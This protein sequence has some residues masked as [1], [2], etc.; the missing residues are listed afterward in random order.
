MT[1]MMLYSYWRRADIRWNEEK[2]VVTV[3]YILGLATT[4]LG[5]CYTFNV[6]VTHFG[7]SYMYLFTTRYDPVFRRWR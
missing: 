4:L 6:F 5:L 1:T 7:D 2:I 3:S